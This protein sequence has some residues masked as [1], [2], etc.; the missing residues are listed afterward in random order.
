[1]RYSVLFATAALAF[2]LAACSHERAEDGGPATARNFTVPSFDKI[3]V[4]GPYSVEVTTGGQP[5]VTAQGPAGIVNKMVVEVEGDTL[6]IHPEKRSG[7]MFG[8][9]SS[10]S[11]GN[12]R[13]AVSVPMLTAAAI[14]GSGEIAVNRIATQDF[15]GAVAGSGGLRLPQVEVQ[16][17]A[18]EIAGSGGV[19]AAG[20]AGDAKYHIA[21]SGDINAERLAVQQAHLEI[22]GSGNIQANAS[23]S[24]KVEIAGSGNVRVTGGAK[25]TI[26]KAGSGD[27][28]CS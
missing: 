7:S 17:L 8:W 13:V 28:Q 18:L 10:G 6:K 22:A 21:G 2:G 1:M 24:A 3:E 15:H 9:G 27:V 25:C 16:S 26:D 5:R 11:H 20:R 23:S 4:A 14:G 19:T 12:A